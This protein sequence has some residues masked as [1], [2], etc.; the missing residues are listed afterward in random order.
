MDG[1]AV[2]VGDEGNQIKVADVFNGSYIADFNKGFKFVQPG[3]QCLDGAG[4]EVCQPAIGKKLM[5]TMMK[6]VGL[7]LLAVLS[8][9]I[10]N[11]LF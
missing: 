10:I 6:H 11:A 7:P 3:G 5:D 1:R 2:K 8:C 4:G 9:F